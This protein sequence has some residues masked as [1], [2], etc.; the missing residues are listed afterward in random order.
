MG[1]FQGCLHRTMKANGLDEDATKSGVSH[2]LGDTWMPYGGSHNLGN[3]WLP[4]GDH[5]FLVTRA[6]KS[7]TQQRG[8]LENSRDSVSKSK[9]AQERSTRIARNTVC[10]HHM[11]VFHQPITAYRLCTP[12]V[13]FPSTNNIMPLRMVTFLAVLNEAL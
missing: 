11:F 4:W 2:I 5:A 13:C 10:V 6:F 12:H 1:C 9:I 7:L 3:T 8:A